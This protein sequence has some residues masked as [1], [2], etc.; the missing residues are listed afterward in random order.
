M[1]KIQIYGA[2]FS[3]LSLAYFFTKAGYQVE[4]Y[5]KENRLGGVIK[6][7]FVHDMLIETAANGFLCSKNIE[8][9]FK[10][11]GCQLSK[12][13]NV[14]RKKYI[15]R[16]GLKTWPL[17]KGETF[18]LIKCFF[19]ALLTF[20][21]KPNNHETLQEWCYRCL[22]PEANHYLLQPMVYG[23]FGT[24]T[25][26]LSAKLVM[27]SLFFPKKPGHIKGLVSANEGMEGVITKLKEYLIKRGTTF[28]LESEKDNKNEILMLHNTFLANSYL[29]WHS[30][31]NSISYKDPL[32]K[33]EELS[34]INSA[35]QRTSGVDLIR[36]TINFKITNL[37]A[38]N[39]KNTNELDGFGVLFP[40]P[41]R[42][43]SL[44][45]LANT[46]IFEN[47]GKYNESWI[48]GGSEHPDYLELA[49]SKIIDLII[50]DRKRIFKDNFEIDNYV[51]IRWPKVLP[52]YNLDLQKEL[53]RFPSFSKKIAGNYLG[54]IGLSGIHER[55]ENLVKE[56]INNEKNLNYSK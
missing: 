27:S 6:S 18:K 5:E 33:K 23:I 14:S 11:I 44:G 8:I 16:Q 48:L 42:F 28:I 51:I 41:E 2:G 52:M 34:Q 15:F 21:I 13:R 25:R 45:V 36:V 12:A 30:T 54:V 32:I 39:Q 20:K 47:R 19:K 9:L 29:F 3:G 26:K 7:Y 4:I 53:E 17:N 40:E 31:F 37:K 43:N 22:T 55:N 56:Y 1:K 46:N 10:D 35:F 49:D 50:Q 24:N 38:P